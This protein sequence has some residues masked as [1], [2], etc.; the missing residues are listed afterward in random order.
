MNFRNRL[1][2]LSDIDV[3]NTK[4]TV[5]A[6][7]MYY[8]LII[9]HNPEEVNIKHTIRAGAVPPGNEKSR[10]IPLFLRGLYFEK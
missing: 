1:I 3:R 6:P 8:A 5:F 10:S 4:I 2:V 7:E 9:L